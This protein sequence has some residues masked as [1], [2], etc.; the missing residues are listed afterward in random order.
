MKMTSLVL[1]ASDGPRKA[2]TVAIAAW[3]LSM[4]LLVPGSLDAFELVD[5]DFD[6]LTPGTPPN[7]GVPAGAW[8]IPQNYINDGWG[9]GADVNI[10]S[11][12][13]T[14]SFD[15]TATGNSFR[16]NLIGSGHHHVTNLFI[17][18]STSISEYTVRFDTYAP[19]GGGGGAFYLAGDH[20]GGGYHYAYDR[21][22]QLAFFTTGELAVV[23]PDGVHTVVAQYDS[24]IWLTFELRVDLI[25]D[26]YDLLSGK[27]GGLLQLVAENVAFR[28]GTLSFLDRV[29]FAAFE[30]YGSSLQ[31]FDNIEVL[32][33]RTE[34]FSDGFES[35]DTTAWTTTV[36]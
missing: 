32:P 2:T 8:L 19:E 15:P 13:T 5:G 31:Y 10:F 1:S 16:I 21:G 17:E 29:S 20:G 33:F 11:V 24:D 22:P 26:S 6:S 23:T 9:E 27:R 34:I 12:V 36:P 7:D 28:S 18:P 4:G 30:E 35:S 25:Q 3:V 14:D